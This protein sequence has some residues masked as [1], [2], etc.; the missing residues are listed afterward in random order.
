MS[1]QPRLLHAGVGAE[2]GVAPPG[3]E[4]DVA[5]LATPLCSRSPSVCIRLEHLDDLA[6]HGCSGRWYLLASCAVTRSSRVRVPRG[7]AGVV[8]PRRTAWRPAASATW[9]R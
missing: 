7:G 3:F 8:S 6:G 2:P 4:L 1:T 9:A 5:V